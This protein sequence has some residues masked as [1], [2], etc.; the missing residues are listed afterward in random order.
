MSGMA[1]FYLAVSVAVLVWLI[2]CLAAFISVKPLKEELVPITEP[3]PPQLPVTC[4]VP[5]SKRQKGLREQY[6]QT[7]K[8]PW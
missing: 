3:V 4:T 8:E 1:W 5:E 7:R 2:R 6:R